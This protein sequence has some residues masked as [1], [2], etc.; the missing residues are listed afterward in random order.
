MKEVT[1]YLNFDGNTEEAFTFYKSVFGGEFA[2]LQRF[3]E[4]PNSESLPTDA[5]QK[6]MHVALPLGSSQVLMGSD[7]LENMGPPLTIGNNFSI[8]IST[9]SKE[10]TD[11][12]FER[13]SVN[14]TVSMPL[15]DTF[16]GSYFGMVT[17]QF[18]I[19]WMVGYDAQ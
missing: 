10:E 17:D 9:G 12:L 14:G 11:T 19:Q 8:S 2:T 4:A 5:M 7:T 18:G 1:I 15:A 3:G 13:L 6:I 16:W